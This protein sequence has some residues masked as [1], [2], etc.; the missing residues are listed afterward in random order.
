MAGSQTKLIH[1]DDETSRVPDVAPPINV[2][3]TFKYPEDP[4]KL[5]TAEEVESEEGWVANG[6]PI[7]S[8]ISHPNSESAEA[9]MTGFLGR[10]TVLYN[11]GLASFNA[12]LFHYHPKRIFFD[13]CY[14]GCHGMANLMTRWG[15][16]EQHTLSDEDL[17][18]YLQAGDL[19]HLETPVNPDGTSF[20]ISYYAQKAHEKGA[21]LSVDSTFAP[22]PL[23]DPFAFGADVVMHSGTKYFGGHSDLLAG[24][25]VVKD[26]KTRHQLLEDRIYLASNISN[27]DAF[28]LLRSLRT[29]ELRIRQQS[30]NA[31]KLVKYLADK[32]GE[33]KVLDKISHSSLQTEA[34]VKKQ[35]PNGFGPVFT[36]EVTDAEIARVF[37]SKLKY[38]HHATSLGGVESLI[39]WRALSNADAAKTILRISVGIEN[40]EDLIEDFDQALRSFN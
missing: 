38:F 17:D 5:V 18:K 33:Y 29:Y 25:L 21:F 23:Q 27:L 30:S 22:Y 16:L 1:C 40:V 15:A 14:H 10:P 19:L 13:R 11:T 24:V 9:L 3:A 7:Y 32:K 35:L 2:A 20:D 37:P 26:S 4:A 12:L 28:L 36:I 8:R 31:E 6:S 34:F 39:E